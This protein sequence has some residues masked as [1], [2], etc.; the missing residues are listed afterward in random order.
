MI[1]IYDA[2]SSVLYNPDDLKTKGV[3]GA[4]VCIV[5]LA[6]E[7]YR[8]N[9]EVIVYN[10]CSQEGVYDG[11]IYRHYNNYVTQHCKMLIG[12][13]SFP[14]RY[15]A[16]K[17][18]NWSERPQKRDAIRFN[19]DKIVSPSNWHK[20][21]LNDNRVVVI[22]NGIEEIFFT[23]KIKHPRR[24]VYAG[25]TG[26]GGMAILPDIYTKIKSK[27]DDVEMIVCG[28]GGLWG[29]NDSKFNQ[30]YLNL[31]NA[32]I[33][34]IGNVSNIELA[35]IM[36]TSSVLINPVGSHHRETFGLVV[37]QAMAS[38]CIPISSGEGNLG[39]LINET[40]FTLFGEISTPEWIDEAVESISEVFNMSEYDLK[41]CQDECRD[42]AKKYTWDKTAKEFLKL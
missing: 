37:G 17:V 9:N 24:I 14:S 22:P 20:G 23:D 5:N 6:K 33:S 3:G 4:E 1:I 15:N 42:E 29:Q 25:F 32:G 31:K 19:V 36:S 16:D 34:Y 8:A 28:D 18:I 35:E 12:C 11:V 39:D 41:K 13:E 38:G 10:N 27:Y 21:F 30:I 40:G 2:K 26:K 7:L